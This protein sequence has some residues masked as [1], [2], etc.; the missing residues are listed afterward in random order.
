MT[1]R[2]ANKSESLPANNPTVGY[3]LALLPEQQKAWSGLAIVP[4]PVGNLGDITL[5]GLEVLRAAD[6][7]LCEDTRT[8]RVLLKHYTIEKPLESHHKFNE[9]QRASQ[10][11]SQMQNGVRVALISDAGTP[12]ISDP[13]SILVS[14]CIE[15][16]VEVTCLPGATAVIPAL[17][18]SGLSTTRFAF[19]GFLPTKKG[20]KTLL[21]SLREE[22]RTLLLYE[23]PYRV[24]TTLKDLSLVLGEDRR[25]AAV[26]EISKLHEQ[27]HRGSLHDLVTYFEA[28]EPRGEFVLVVEGAEEY[29]KRLRKEDKEKSKSVEEPLLGKRSSKPKRQIP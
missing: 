13:G 8:S 18:M 26:R 28:S 20:R 5:R 11:V 6:L 16:G 17:L 29:R 24:L 15:G 2:K 23:S 12:G 1:H 25:A 9:Y 10:L 7:I 27:A 21:E 4:T 19:E 22:P 14:S 3:D